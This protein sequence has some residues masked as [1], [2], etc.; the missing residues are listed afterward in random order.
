M[1]LDE[2]KQACSSLREV[3]SGDAIRTKALEVLK[4][5]GYKPDHVHYDI[6]YTSNKGFPL[7]V[8]AA[9]KSDTK[10]PPWIIL[11][12]QF[13]Y[14]NPDS[15]DF[16]EWPG[17]RFSWAGEDKRSLKD[18]YNTMDCQFSLVISNDRVAVYDGIELQ[19]FSTSI[20]SD[21]SD[22]SSFSQPISLSAR[23]YDDLSIEEFYDN[24]KAPETLP[25]AVDE[26][27]NEYRKRFIRKH[28]RNKD[29]WVEISICT[30]NCH[31]SLEDYWEKLQQVKNAEDRIQKGNSLEELG[32]LIFESIEGLT[33]RAENFRTTSSELD[34]I[35]E[36]KPNRN[37]NIF[38]GFGRFFLV[39]CKNWESSV[40]ANEVR[41]LRTKMENTRTDLGILLAKNGVTGESGK[42]AVDEMDKL[43]QK[44]GKLMI[45]M[46]GNDLNKI[47]YG[48]SPYEIIDTKLFS[49]RFREI[50]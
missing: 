28:I 29:D 46:N 19:G 1:S 24:I 41:D 9:I 20:V 18:I 44:R 10:A 11:S 30:D 14:I 23:G 39:E 50:I 3:E 22:E 7:H 31:L 8:D 2:F 32:K 21:D 43:F 33:I 34:L 47:T 6:S 48:T 37:I 45:V 15:D 27:N 40:G 12:T 49:R 17:H 42:D 36:R 38:D 35:I 13:S 16:H 26:A 4:K 25:D 5:L